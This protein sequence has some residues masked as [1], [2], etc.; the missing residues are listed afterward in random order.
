MKFLKVASII[1]LD[2]KFLVTS[3]PLPQAN[4]NNGQIQ[5]NG[6]GI[7][8]AEARADVTITEQIFQGIQFRVAVPNN[9]QANAGLNVLLHGDGGQSFFEFPNVD[10]E[11]QGGLIGVVMLSPLS[12][13]GQL[14]WGGDDNQ[15][16]DGPAQMQIV[17]DIIQNEIPKIVQFDQSKV[18]F[19][20]VSGGSLTL[21]SAML[22]LFGDVFQSGMMILC[23]GLTN[24]LDLTGKLPNRLHFQTTQDE[25][26]GIKEELPVTIK[27]IADS[28][29]A[30]GLADAQIQQQFT[31]NGSPNAG[32]CA[33][34][35]QDF[36]SGIQLML[37]QFADIMLNAQ[38]TLN[39]GDNQLNGIIG[40]E[41]PFVPEGEVGNA[42]GGQAA[43]ANENN[44]AANNAADNNAA[45]NNAANNAADNN[46]ADNNA[47]NNAADNNAANNAAE[48]VN[49]GNISDDEDDDDQDNQDN[50]DDNEDD[51]GE[52]QD[53]DDNDEDDDDQGNEDDDGQDSN[54]DNDQG[55]DNNNNNKVATAVLNN[56]GVNAEQKNNQKSN[57]K[58]K[59]GKATNKNSVKSLLADMLKKI[60]VAN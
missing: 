46:A 53:N 57:K 5:G 18:F 14:K 29:Q 55:Q 39:V 12:P 52:N 28:A 32:H 59:A 58:S 8:E 36:N 19:T 27:E 43:V 45:D 56:K 4:N 42:G 31:V 23:G 30:Q 41:N 50:D 37:D 11:K 10:P 40:N 48:N 38:P 21:T 1:L 17:T 60:G 33:F 44:N 2:L 22:P 20:G 51:Q 16:S 54:D 9:L 25:L 13:N 26:D 6:Q 15:R 7:S 24:N 49:Q 47:A 34:D 3:I 35:G